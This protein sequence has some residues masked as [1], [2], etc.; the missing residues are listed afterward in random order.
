MSRNILTLADYREF[1]FAFARFF[2]SNGIELFTT[3][4]NS[5][6]FFSWSRCD[7]CDGSLG[8]NREEI[9]AVTLAGN[10]G[11]FTVCEDCVYY[12]EYGRLDDSTMLKM[13]SACDI[14][15]WLVQ[16]GDCIDLEGDYYADP[17]RDHVEY[18]F[19]LQVV[20]SVER[21]TD[22]CVAISILNGPQIGFPLNHGLKWEKI[23]EEFV[24]A[25]NEV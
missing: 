11:E 2:V 1:Q 19:E 18:E 3:K 14:P 17:N 9:V 4:D 21:E 10:L 7:C 13:E 6:P 24:K 20:E 25:L 15:A 8:G 22:D 23:D 16:P 12:N 5:E